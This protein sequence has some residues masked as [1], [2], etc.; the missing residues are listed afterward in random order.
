[1]H[2]KTQRIVFLFIILAV[3]LLLTTGLTLGKDNPLNLLVTQ[4]PVTNG[5][6]YQGQ[7]T[8]AGASAEGVFD[9]QFELYDAVTDGT[10]LGMVTLENVIV[11][12][13]LFTVLLDFGTGTFD[14]QARW[15]AIGV[16]A[17]TE[18]GA[19]TPLTHH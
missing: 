1:M 8:T 12:E 2:S 11:T 18:T 13:G 16:R 6:T 10:L 17:G 14:G 3:L 9:L 7:L 4:S 15:L 19:Y 5:F